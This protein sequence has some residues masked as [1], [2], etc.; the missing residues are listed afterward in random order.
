MGQFLIVHGREP[1]TVRE[2][3]ARGV[4]RFERLGAGRPEL[5]FEQGTTAVARFPRRCAPSPASDERA[6]GWA[7][8]AGCWLAA[9]HADGAALAG[10]GAALRSDLHE[11][12]GAAAKLDGFFAFAAGDAAGRELAVATDRTGTLHV[13]RVRAEG[14]EL[15]STS[16]LVL[17]T[18]AGAEFDPLAVREF[19]G[20]GSVFEQRS[21]HA[22]VEKLPPATV[23]RFRDGRPVGRERW[24][25]LRP[26]LWGSQESLAHPGDV[27]ALAG[28]LTA[29]LDALLAAYPA[30][31]LDLTGGFDSRAVLGAALATAR[32][33]RTV[34][35]GADDDPD[36]LAAG[37]IA[38]AF[39]LSHTHL[40]P[41]RDYGARSLADLQQ[42]LALC[43]G[44]ADVVEYAGI[45]QIQARMAGAG[46]ASR[47]GGLTVNGSSG[48]L[49]RGYWWDLLPA[50]DA[51]GSA[52]DSRRAA[53]GRFATDGW[54]DA[55]LAGTGDATASG[56]DGASASLADHFTAVVERSNAELRDL[57]AVALADNTYLT[58][59]M[60][61]WA[62]RLVSATDRIWPCVSP[63]MFEAPMRA[64]LSAPPALRR[65][66][67]MTR[68]LIEHL[69]PRLA[70]L[71]MADGSPALPLRAGTLH[72]FG[73]HAAALG[74]KAWGR[75]RRRM[76]GGAASG[77]GA[78]GVAA[79]DGVTRL[80]ADA[81]IAG[82]LSP[83][84]MVTHELYDRAALGSFL[85]ASRAVGF[86][87]PRRFGRV[88]TLE[89]VA[90]VLGAR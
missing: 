47:T 12:Q 1:A 34:V 15:L 24:W 55:M 50:L 60:Q 77:G 76:G 43:D 69:N 86:D 85:A 5:R 4:Q 30:A 18:L 52:F 82:L 39:E 78:A 35:V 59:R 90:R 37:G 56:G 3:L 84:S 66:D 89:L 31:V 67:R 42:A 22:G 16:S 68:A 41:G 13:Y 28:A 62:G 10:L 58:L 87:Q 51:P 75:V 20:T 26:L 38:R 40:V 63:F 61:R 7:V 74:G 25:E 46:G 48:E 27:P 54:A 14:C 17:A 19:L 57:S 49:C 2:L 23:L 73:P 88:L 8:A 33:F 44:E 29:A 79:A 72:R 71:P 11:W 80:W 45:A 81:D 6:P 21:L 9:R 70:V 32:P 65:R 53:I 36:V 83:E 64:A